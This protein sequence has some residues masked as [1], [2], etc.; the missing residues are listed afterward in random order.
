MSRSLFPLEAG[1]AAEGGRGGLRHRGAQ[2]G[3]AAGAPRREHEAQPGR[4]RGDKTSLTVGQETEISVLQPQE[5]EFN[6]Q[7]K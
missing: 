4:T 1:D 3:A 7:L 6:Q 5:A 2:L